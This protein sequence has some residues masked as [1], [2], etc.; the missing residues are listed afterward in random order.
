MFKTPLI[1]TQV[2]R[3]LLKEKL[4]TTSIMALFLHYK[5]HYSP[6]APHPKEIHVYVR[7]IEALVQGF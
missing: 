6:S 5:A 4:K 7:A 2:R 1:V 3:L